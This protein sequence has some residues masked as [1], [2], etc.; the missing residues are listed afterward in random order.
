[1]TDVTAT[2]RTTATNRTGLHHAQP[3]SVASEVES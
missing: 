2:I 1:M 3:R